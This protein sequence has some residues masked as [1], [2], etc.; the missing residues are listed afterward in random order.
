MAQEPPT[1]LSG[2]HVDRTGVF[3]NKGDVDSYTI[4]LEQGKDYIYGGGYDCGH[5][6]MKVTGPNGLSMTVIVSDDHTN[7]REFRALGAGKHTITVIQKDNIF[8][9]SYPQPYRILFD[10][11]CKRDV[12]TKCTNY[13]GQSKGGLITVAV[14]DV[15]AYRLI[16][17]IAGATYTWSVSGVSE[18]NSLS[19]R[20][21][22]GDI[23]S[24]S[25]TASVTFKAT[26]T[27][28]LGVLTTGDEVIEGPYNTQLVRR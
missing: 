1:P 10:K 5:A 27:T 25:G 14:G 24:S 2:T 22:N 9:S 16:N 12:H 13:P 15:D 23:V 8:C 19:I 28:M 3:D 11:D 26:Y 17:L 7:G 4:Y 21:L 18:V 6:D 20:K